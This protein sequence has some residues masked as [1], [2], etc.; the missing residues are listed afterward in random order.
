MIIKFPSVC[1]HVSCCVAV[2]KVLPQVV[3]SVTPNDARK[4]F[5]E[6][7]EHGMAVVI[8]TVKVCLLFGIFTLFYKFVLYFV[9]LLLITSMSW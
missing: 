2:A 8:V 6:P 1:I 3:P 5:H 9:F 7:R 4:L